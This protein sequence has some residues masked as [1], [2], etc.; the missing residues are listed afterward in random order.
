MKCVKSGQRPKM[1]S[2]SAIT[3]TFVCVL[4][5][6]MIGEAQFLVERKRKAGGVKEMLQDA[7][8]LTHKLRFL[9][10]E[11]QKSNC[12]CVCLCVSIFVHAHPD[13]FLCV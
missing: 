11:V 9:V 5:E 1:C 13:M 12:V 10:V 8:K 4:Q 6:S 3:T 7:T 2:T